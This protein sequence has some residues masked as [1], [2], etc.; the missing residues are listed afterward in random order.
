M[1]VN[2]LIENNEW[3]TGNPK[4]GIGSLLEQYFLLSLP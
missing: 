4:Q 3:N 1:D 2:L